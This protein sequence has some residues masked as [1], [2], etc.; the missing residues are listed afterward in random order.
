MSP[1][2]KKKQD[3]SLFVN[4][5]SP[6]SSVNIKTRRLLISLSWK[7]YCRCSA[8]G[9]RKI[10][11]LPLATW[12]LAKVSSRATQ[13]EQSSIHPVIIVVSPLNA[14]ISDQIRRSTEG[15]VKAAILNVRKGKN[16]EDLELDDTSDGNSSWLK[17]AR[18]DIIFTHPKAVLSCKKGMEL[19]QSCSKERARRERLAFLSWGDFHTRSRFARFTIPDEKRGLLVVTARSFLHS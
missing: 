17:D 7:G 10:Y 11:N 8:N 16:G 6:Q 3:G 14:L 4:V 12:T 18:Y 2:R 13:T 15:K 1:R 19:F 9:I 5:L